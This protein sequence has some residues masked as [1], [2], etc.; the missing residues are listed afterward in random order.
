M[1]IVIF[2]FVLLSILESGCRSSEKEVEIPE[3]PVVLPV[4]VTDSV[5]YD[6][7]DPAIWIDRTDPANSLILGTDKGDDGTDGAL[8]VFNLKGEILPA[9]T[10]H[11]LKRP[12][13]V[14]VAYGLAVGDS[15]FDVA[16]LAERNANA[17]RVFALPDMRSLDGN[18]I[19]VFEGDSLRAPMGIAL[20]T[21]PS[22]ELYAFVSRKAGPSGSYVW[23]YQLMDGGD[24]K[25][26]AKVVRKFGTF[27]GKNEIESVAID[28]ELGYV[29]Y[30]DES[31]GVRK[32]YAHPDST[33]SELALFA[34]SG[35]TDNHE[36]I[37]IYK[38]DDNTGYILVSDQQANLF[39]IFPREGSPG[40]PHEHPLLY[41]FK[42]TTNESDGSEV[43]STSLPNFSGGIFIAMSDDK[44]FH[45]Y[46]WKDIAKDELKVKEDLQVNNQ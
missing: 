29:Y 19:P 21:L 1:R 37:S 31:V 10:I 41:S 24:G 20:Y 9:K 18:G 32:Y 43:S 23:Q 45:F 42:P 30:S 39:H 22:G 46:R 26:V 7:D 35:F 6:S 28:Q 33:T 34:T 13:N 15:V 14:D 17:L 27:S 38:L 40:K 4:I 36:G 2:V 25:V 44:T 3:V 11:G 8:F 12:N 16:I 5:N